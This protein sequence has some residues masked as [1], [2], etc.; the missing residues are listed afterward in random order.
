VPSI[1]IGLESFTACCTAGGA[2]VGVSPGFGALRYDETKLAS[3]KDAKFDAA[4]P[5]VRK[6]KAIPEAMWLWTEALRLRSIQ[7]GG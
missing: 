2:V 7:P 3:L 1:S 5:A 4:F 6:L